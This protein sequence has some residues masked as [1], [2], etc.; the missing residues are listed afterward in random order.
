MA[1]LRIIHTYQGCTEINQYVCS[2][3]FSRYI[4]RYHYHIVKEHNDQFL[5]TIESCRLKKAI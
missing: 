1:L 3:I 4:L 5:L 2:K